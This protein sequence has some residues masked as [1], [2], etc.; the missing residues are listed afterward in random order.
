IPGN[1]IDPAAAAVLNRYPLPNV[2]T[3]G[4]EAT[5]NNFIR[6]GNETTNQEQFGIRLDH[7]LNQN[8]RLFGRYEYFRDDSVPLAPLPDGSGLITTA[9]IGNTLT[10]A[11]SVA[12][13]DSWT[14]SGNTVNQLRFGYTRRGFHRDALRTGQNASDITRIPNIP[15]S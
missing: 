10:R 11:D 6:V 7:N 12:L 4:R 5:A 8:N 9:I 14:L 13:E 1:R 2:F 3:G 15:A